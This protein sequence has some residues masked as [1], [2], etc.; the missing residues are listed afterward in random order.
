MDRT[1]QRVS[2]MGCACF[3]SLPLFSPV[4]SR[5]VSERGGCESQCKRRAI[6]THDFYIHVFFAFLPGEQ[7]LVNTALASTM[8]LLSRQ[9][10]T[11]ACS[12][13]GERR[14]Q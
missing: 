10:Q 13:L 8:L 1:W 6:S 12:C 14:R 7:Q 9:V 3:P 4:M 2:D 11:S 5:L